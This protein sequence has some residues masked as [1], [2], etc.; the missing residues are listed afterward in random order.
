MPKGAPPGLTWS[1]A[2][3]S[4]RG[5]GLAGRGRTCAPAVAATVARAAAGPWVGGG[6]SPG[7]GAPPARSKFSIRKLLPRLPKPGAAGKWRSAEEATTSQYAPAWAATALGSMV[8]RPRA[9]RTP[10]CQ[11]ARPGEGGEGTEDAGRLGTVL[12]I[13]VGSFLKDGRSECGRGK[14]CAFLA[15]RRRLRGLRGASLPLFMQI[16][17]GIFF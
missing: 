13:W 9:R 8:R 7:G 2:G 10:A 4:F 15:R 12:F 16:R 5:T 1:A 3:H 14:L 11:P 17:T 6:G